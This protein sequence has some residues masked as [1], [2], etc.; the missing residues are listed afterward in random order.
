MAV[1]IRNQDNDGWD[2]AAGPVNTA[3]WVVDST[4]DEGPRLS[5]NR[6]FALAAFG[7]NANVTATNVAVVVL[8]LY[9]Q[10]VAHPSRQ[11]KIRCWLYSDASTQIAG[12]QVDTDL[13]AVRN[14][15]DHDPRIDLMPDSWKDHMHEA[16]HI[17]FR[18]VEVVNNWDANMRL[19]DENTN[20]PVLVAVVR[21]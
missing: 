13:I 12:T 9:P 5:T 19:W 20:R 16:T 6:V 2:L 18:G 10:V 1:E 11:G 14:L 4:D 21:T 7:T 17:G 8:L 15:A 3:E